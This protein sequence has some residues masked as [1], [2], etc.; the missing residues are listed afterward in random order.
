MRVGRYATHAPAHRAFLIANIGSI[1]R[2]RRAKEEDGSGMPRVTR[3]VLYGVCVPPL[4][5]T[6][7]AAGQGARLGFLACAL[8]VF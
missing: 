6:A 3:P 7:F 8:S 2:A 1:L 4:P 5:R